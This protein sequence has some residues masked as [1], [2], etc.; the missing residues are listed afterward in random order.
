M[1]ARPPQHLPRFVP[2]MLAKSAAPFDSPEHLFE[3]KW[4]GTGA[5]ALVERGGL[6]LLNR[7]RVEMVERYPEFAFLGRLRPGLVLDGEVVVLRD[8]KR[9]FVLL[10]SR[11]HTRAPLKVRSLA[12]ALP[13]TYVVFDLL[14][15]HFKSQM[16][17]PLTA[18]R[19]RLRQIVAGCGS[20]Q[21]VL[22]EG[23]EGRGKAFFREACARGLEG[24]MAKRLGSPYLP[25]RRTDAWTKIK[26][27]QTVTRALIGFV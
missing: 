8:G 17:L 12:R 18:R 26:R 2:P 16:S 4:D 7:R 20:P 14:Y 25:G 3:V 11:E 23:V 21:L 5:W 6:R 9:D 10:Q 27:T 13:A 22:S 19:E 1:A 24:V 15:D